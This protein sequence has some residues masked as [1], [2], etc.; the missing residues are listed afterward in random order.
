MSVPS[1][2]TAFP[3]A[4]LAMGAAS[5]LPSDVP[6]LR[7]VAGR[8]LAISSV[9]STGGASVS[10]RVSSPRS[11]ATLVKAADVAASTPGACGLE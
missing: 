4:I 8:V 10:A 1:P 2:F 6:D 9:T 11:L 5:G 3:D 7:A